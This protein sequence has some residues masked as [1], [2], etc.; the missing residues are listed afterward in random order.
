[1]KYTTLIFSAIVKSPLFWGVLVTVIFYTFLHNGTI[2]SEM[3]VRYLA[4]HPI[5]YTETGMFFIGMCALGLKAFDLLYQRNSLQ[6]G[7]ILPPIREH[8]VDTRSCEAYLRQVELFL[9]KNGPAY[10]PNR[11]FKA[12]KFVRQC[13]SAEQLDSELKYLAEDDAINAESDYAF[14]L[15]IIWAIPTTVP[16]KPRIGIAQIISCTNP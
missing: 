4:M 9:K 15:L 13:E 6:A 12:L 14:V 1:M 11:L 8:R 5:E 2:K 16:K 3:L 10:Y 7:P